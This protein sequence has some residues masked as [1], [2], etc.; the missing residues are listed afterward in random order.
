MLE[1]EIVPTIGEAVTI[2]RNSVKAFNDNPTISEFDASVTTQAI[3]EN[4]QIR[5]FVMGL[6]AEGV[7]VRLMV[8]WLESLKALTPKE[9][10]TPALTI[11]SAFYYEIG[12]QAKSLETL[13][14]ADEGYPL[15]GLIRRVVFAGWPVDSFEQMRKELHPTV[16]ENLQEWWDNTLASE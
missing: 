5:D 2:I 3:N 7:D 12:S 11:L 6:P 9:L 10:S 14:E 4:L 8:A 15:A 1:L 13:S 16:V